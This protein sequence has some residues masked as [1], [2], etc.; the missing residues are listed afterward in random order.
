MHLHAMLH[1]LRPQDTLKM[2]SRK[3]IFRDQGHGIFKVIEPPVFCIIGRSAGKFVGQA[4]ALY[5]N[6]V[7]EWTPRYA[8]VDFIG[9]RLC[10]TS[11]DNHWASVANLG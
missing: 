6:C 3:C 7:D 1:L 9:Y 11:R 10:G 4:Y 2:V 5:G 8:G